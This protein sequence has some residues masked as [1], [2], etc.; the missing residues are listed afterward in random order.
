MYNIPVNTED[1][2]CANDAA[3]LT[4]PDHEVYVA[5]KYD[6]I[7]SAIKCNAS[8]LAPLGTA[9]PKSHAEK[10]PSRKAPDTFVIAK[11]RSYPKVVERM[12][13]WNHTSVVTVAAA[14]SRTM[15]RSCCVRVRY[16]LFL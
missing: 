8:V 13:D 11:T 2:T 5:K 10:N 7:S 1:F 4:I 15:Q 14:G 12:A 6:R 9:D 16:G 3:T